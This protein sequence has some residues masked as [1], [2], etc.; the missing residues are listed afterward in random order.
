MAVT[1][2]KGGAISVTHQRSLIVVHSQAY[3]NAKRNVN[4]A[5]HI[6]EAEQLIR[7]IKLAIHWA[8]HY[9]QD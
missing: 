8:Y 7:D 5:L 2:G 3:A 4:V 6:E 1:E 9:G